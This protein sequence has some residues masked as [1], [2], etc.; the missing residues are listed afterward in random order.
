MD[1]RKHSP[2]SQVRKRFIGAYWRVAAV[3]AL[4]WFGVAAL[5]WLTA[6]LTVN[7][8]AIISGLGVLLSLV[9]ALHWSTGLSQTKLAG[10]LDRTHPELEDSVALLD[11]DAASLTLPA[12][13]Q[14]ERVEQHLGAISSQS[15]RLGA[16]LPAHLMS[17]MVMAIA[18]AALLV[19]ASRGS[20]APV[21]S[22][23]SSFGGIE[24]SVEQSVSPPKYTGAK[25]FTSEDAS[26]RFPSGSTVTV[27]AQ[28]PPNAEKPT[29]VFEDGSELELTRG[30]EGVWLAKMQVA[31]DRAWQVRWLNGSASERDVMFSNVFQWFATPDAPPAIRFRVPETTFNT[32]PDGAGQ[33]TVTAEVSD[34][35]GVADVAVSGTLAKGS[36]ENVRFR[37]AA[38]PFVREQQ[39]DVVLVSLGESTETLEMEPGDELYVR[40]YAEDERQPEANK[41]QSRALVFRWPAERIGIEADA[42]VR[43]DRMPDY[44]RS[45]RQIIIDTE[46]LI[47]EQAEID[48]AEFDDRSRSLAF[49]QAALRMRYGEFLGEETDAGVP[50]ATL[51]AASEQALDG[52]EDHDSHEGHE[53][54]GSGHSHD[55]SPLTAE[56]ANLPSI[57]AEYA[58]SHDFREQA[59]LFDDATKATLRGVINAMWSAEAPLHLSKPEDALPH[60]YRALRMLKALQQADRI[61]VQRVGFSAP[62]LMEEKRLTGELDE[63]SSSEVSTFDQDALANE[64]LKKLNSA[65]AKNMPH[66]L[67]QEEYRWV[68]SEIEDP[69]VLLLA[70]RLAQDASCSDCI[71]AV[72]SWLWQRVATQP[73]PWVA[74]FSD[75]AELPAGNEGRDRG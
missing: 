55:E 65:L 39:N 15:P 18:F 51:D 23:T 30:S 48:K 73:P 28:V 3:G 24:I 14:R 36:G 66:E 4:A 75:D 62:P 6:T 53:P 72:R 64:V 38:L 49:D 60:E 68:T 22:E 10:H 1:S 56:F 12:L 44:F 59:T 63:A 21:E 2:L 45:Q 16:L 40:V 57:V 17:Q 8:A 34:D 54:A 47:A 67:T 11:G 69:K 42:A 46:K 71:S 29:M 50:D 43:I 31:L 52:H 61:Y 25:P 7:Q 33:I 26:L 35:Y 19:L 41:V 32:I 27:Q 5:A 20:E 13:L 70:S 37:D 74:R 9:Y 58:H